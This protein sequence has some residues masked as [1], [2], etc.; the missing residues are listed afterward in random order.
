V[1]LDEGGQGFN[2]GASNLRGRK[3]IATFVELLVEN[4]GR[5]GDTS[6]L[7]GGGVGGET[8]EEVITVLLGGGREDGGGDVRGRGDIGDNDDLVSLG[9]LVVTLGGDI[10]NSG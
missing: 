2:S 10:R 9:E 3:I 6:S 7:D 5:R 1:L 4:N 8:E